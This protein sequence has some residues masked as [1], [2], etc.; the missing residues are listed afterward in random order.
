MYD[1]LLFP[2][3]LIEID[4]GK[5]SGQA[6]FDNMIEQLYK[7]ARAICVEIADFQPDLVVVLAHGGWGVLWAV[8]AYWVASRGGQPFP[9]VM[10]TNLGREKME[11]YERVR[12]NLPCA[13]IFPFMGEY[14]GDQEVG[15][16]L[17][18]L[19]G[20]QDWIE[21]FRQQ[22]QAARSTSPERVLILDDDMMEGCTY[23]LSIGLAEAAFPKADVH[24][25]NGLVL[26]WRSELAYPW[27]AKHIPDWSEA[28]H[29]KITHALYY[30]G[31][32]TEDI[33]I[34]SLEWKPITAQSPVMEEVRAL[35]PPEKWLELPGWMMQTI[36][37]QV[38][39][40]YQR[41]AQAQT[42]VDAGQARQEDTKTPVIENRGITCDEAILQYVWLHGS[43]TRR[44]AEALF[45]PYQPPLDRILR[46]L[47]EFGTLISEGTG[48][49]RC[50][51]LP[52][53]ASTPEEM[54]PPEPVLD[55]FWVRPGWLLA[56]VGPNENYPE[57]AVE[58]VRWLS[59][60]GVT[61]LVHALI[62]NWD[63]GAKCTAAVQA[64]GTPVQLQ[65][66]RLPRR[67]RLSA[68]AEAIAA[69]NQALEQGEVVY[70]S[71]PDIEQAAAI[72]ACWLVQQGASGPQALAQVTQMRRSGFQPWHTY[73]RTRSWRQLVL[74]W[75]RFYRA[76]SHSPE[77]SDR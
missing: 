23:R 15:Y 44:E 26:A 51:I 39:E 48:S 37:A 34:E 56:G 27:L 40:R 22:A 17:A 43:I 14:A 64:A 75:A 42:A 73:P 6:R 5:L 66:L 58:Q 4:R 30:L 9:P 2:R 21:Q 35:L 11:R 18:W 70:L 76:L 10:V 24:F 50:Y 8:E 16:F 7:T 33:H 65:L 32:G 57:T 3:I 20:Q 28:K 60:R 71:A 63:D 12:E 36:Q 61:R 25:I 53:E 52:P 67:G 45:A 74:R 29:E 38:Q 41:D 31:P 72:A 46:G 69:A 49:A 54:L 19:A 55:A 1:D 47:L 62:L 77:T 59:G 68:M 13:H